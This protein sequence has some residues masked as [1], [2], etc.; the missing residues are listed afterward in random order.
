MRFGKRN[1]FP[2]IDPNYEPI[3]VC[4]RLETYLSI[5][6]TDPRT[7][8]FDNLARTSMVV[9]KSFQICQRTEEYVWDFRYLM[10]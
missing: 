6:S 3:R 4:G 7:A 9:L 5:Q 1:F 8:Q 2:S 10:W